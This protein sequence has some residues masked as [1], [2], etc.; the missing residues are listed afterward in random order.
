MAYACIAINIPIDTH[1]IHYRASAVSHGGTQTSQ[2][3]RNVLHAGTADCDQVRGL[4]RDLKGTLSKAMHHDPA[5]SH[6]SVVRLSCYHKMGPQRLTTCKGT[7]RGQ[8]NMRLK[9]KKK[10]KKKERP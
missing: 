9:K 8:G 10:K 6:G 4:C 1:T 3:P 7:T 5:H 2:A